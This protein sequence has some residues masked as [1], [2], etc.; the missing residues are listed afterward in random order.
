M[1]NMTNMTNIIYN[2]F[3][4]HPQQT[5]T[6]QSYVRHGL[7][8]ISNSF[9][10]IISGFAGIVHGFIPNLFPFYTSGIVIQSFQKLLKSGRHDNEILSLFRQELKNDRVIIIKSDNRAPN[11]IS[12]KNIQLTIKLEEI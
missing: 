8:A 7:F 11:C 1:T 2:L 4:D 9:R 3:N 12:V 6:P 5:R 10:L